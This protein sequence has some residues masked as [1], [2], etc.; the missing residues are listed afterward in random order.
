MRKATIIAAAIICALVLLVWQLSADPR[1]TEDKYF[2][3]IFASQA[4]P[5]VPRNAHTFATF[6]KCPH[7][8][9]DTDGASSDVEVLTIS[10]LP[11][12]MEIVPVRL[13][14]ESG[15]NLDLPATLQWA[16]SMKARIVAWGPCEIK[17]ELFDLARQQ[18]ERLDRGR[19]GYKAL[20][21]RFR[22]A[23]ASNCIHAVCD[24]DTENGLLATGTAFGEAASFMVLRHLEHWIVDPQKTYPKIADRLQFA[25]GDIRFQQMTA[26]RD[27]ER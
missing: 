2:M 6:V 1:P 24:I 14:S 16:R 9:T 10:W 11:A 25:S 3:I 22:G 7:P 15:K 18:V 13:A 12:S 17:K 21:L 5:V 26:V 27:V 23:G 4:E 20:D 8:A 19:I